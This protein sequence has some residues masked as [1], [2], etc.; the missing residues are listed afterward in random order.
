MNQSIIH[1]G[2]H[3]T[4][5]TYL[6][7]TLF[8]SL[9][10]VQVI[11]G[12]TPV[13]D[14]I[15]IELNKKRLISDE[16]LSGRLWHGEYLQD[17]YESIKR[18]K[19]TYHNPKIIFGIRR[20]EAF[21][22][23]IYKQYLHSK[24]YKKFDHIFNKENTG[25]FKHEDLFFTSRID[26][27]KTHFSEENLFFYT[28]ESLRKREKD[29]V[30]ALAKFMEL[31]STDIEI[32]QN[33][34]FTNTGVKT[35]LQV[36]MLIRLNKINAFLEKIHPSIGLYSYLYRKCRITPRKICQSYLAGFKSK[37]FELSNSDKEFIISYY[38]SDWDNASKLISY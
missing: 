29:F 5:T 30:T 31:E 15:N 26:Y 3:K 10:N 8:R 28:Q 4:G 11:L 1:I 21:I 16:A 25:V 36:R 17:F 23:S 12:N 38:A 37:K 7:N 24:G 13:R 6:Q 35:Q 19:A 2:L 27:L 18:I 32:K 14:S 9:P 33:K 22:L 34:Q 20:H